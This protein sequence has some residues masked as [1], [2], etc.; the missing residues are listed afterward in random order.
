M[1]SVVNAVYTNIVEFVRSS[2]QALLVHHMCANQT[3]AVVRSRQSA[4][5]SPLPTVRQPLSAV[6]QS[7]QNQIK[8]LTTDLDGWPRTISVVH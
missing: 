5:D 7:C 6:A 1:L 2:V 3:L 8:F 4:A